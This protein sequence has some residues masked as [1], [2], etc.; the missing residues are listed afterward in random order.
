MTFPQGYIQCNQPFV[1]YCSLGVV[2]RYSRSELKVPGLSPTQYLIVFSF[3]IS[4]F[5]FPVFC[6]GVFYKYIPKQMLFKK[7][8]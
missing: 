1:G 2:I 7:V 6:V 4:F 8:Q 5:F 3:F